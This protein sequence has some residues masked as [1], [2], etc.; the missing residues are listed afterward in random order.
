MSIL[1]RN[2]LIVDPHADSRRGL[3]V[4]LRQSG[5]MVSIV[6]DLFEC[7]DYIEKHPTDLVLATNQLPH[8][9]ST[10][11]LKRLRVGALTK[12]LPVFIYSDRSD[13]PTI[14]RYIAS[15]ATEFILKPFDKDPL[16]QKL[17]R[18][19]GGRPRFAEYPLAQDDTGYSEVVFKSHVVSIGEAG[20]V[21]WSP[22]PLTEDTTHRIRAKVFAQ[23]G[24][25]S[26]N[27][28]VA[29]CQPGDDG[30]FVHF[31]FAGMK[32]KDVQNVRSW[33]VDKTLKDSALANS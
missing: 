10:D 11:L 3:E 6:N 12:D 15:G 1:K 4:I 24:I 9:P 23:I 32:D 17:E 2:L 19:L 20:M 28:K 30:F 31:T 22:I 5:Y 14:Q 8:G 27:L 25:H 7:L 16:L 29:Y 33:V 26:P 13:K 21:I 18:I